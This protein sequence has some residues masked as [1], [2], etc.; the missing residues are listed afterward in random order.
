MLQSVVEKMPWD[1]SW[2]LEHATR[3]RVTIKE[4]G[5]Q[6]RIIR[7][8]LNRARENDT[9]TV[10]RGWRNEL[11]PIHGHHDVME[12][13]IS[14]ER[15]GSAL[16]G[17]NSYGV[18]MTSYVRTPEGMKIWVPRRAKNKSTYGGMLDNT[19]AGGLSTGETPLGCLIR[20]ASEEA[21][22]PEQLIRANAKPCGTVSYIHVRDK[23][24]GGETGLIQPE[25]Q[26]IYDM[27][28]GTEVIP[29]PEDD[30]VEEFYLWTIEEVTRS[31]ANGEFKPNCAVVLLDFLIRHSILTPENESDYMEIVSR[32]HRKLPFPTP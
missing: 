8:T 14:M 4:M 9:F 27:E 30:E 16:F 24:A 19:V 13:T 5:N 31:L 26:Y 10:L 20:E 23:L 22:L 7:D 15:A 21:S 12:E 6:E 32:I 25:C 18:H 11:Y 17:I 3:K 28:V 2:Y 1:E 29:N